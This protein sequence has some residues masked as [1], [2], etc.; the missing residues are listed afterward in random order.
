ML[1]F[2]T[3]QDAYRDDGGTFGT[4]YIYK[5]KGRETG[6]RFTR[7]SPSDDF[8]GL[9]SD[10]NEESFDSDGWIILCVLD[11]DLFPFANLILNVL[12]CF[13]VAV[14]AGNVDAQSNGQRS[15]PLS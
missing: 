7:P 6:E 12:R 2:H 13:F 4:G 1:Q 14:E 11:F 9:C 5:E 15:K 10:G 8:T 3:V